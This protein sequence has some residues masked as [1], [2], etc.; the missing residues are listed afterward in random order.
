VSHLS[1]LLALSLE[2]VEKQQLMAERKQWKDWPIIAKELKHHIS[3]PTQVIAL[4]VRELKEE[5]FKHA[6]QPNLHKETLE[7]L[8]RRIQVI[9]R[10]TDEIKRVCNYLASVSTEIPIEKHGF[11]LLALV[12]ESVAE[13]RDEVRNKYIDLRED[14]PEDR[15][16]LDAD[17]N[18]VKYCLQCVLRNAIEAIEEQRDQVLDTNFDPKMAGDHIAVHLSREPGKVRLSIEDTGVGIP[19]ENWDRVFQPMFST[20]H[21]LDPGGIGLF[22]VRRIMNQHDG[23]VD[24]DRTVKKGASFTLS[25]PYA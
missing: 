21:K 6:N 16:S 22:S 11:D 2:L 24:F 13:I 18:L 25:F 9:E 1:D 19:M 14:L 10:N 12:R 23:T 5:D 17:P 15:L 7:T 4:H 20:K 3:T 8:S